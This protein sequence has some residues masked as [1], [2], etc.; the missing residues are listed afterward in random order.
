[1]EKICFDMSELWLVCG[2]EVRGGNNAW[3]E[4]LNYLFF[5]FHNDT[6]RFS[7]GEL[8]PVQ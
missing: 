6:S 3:G 8:S 5:E 4:H 2:A 7:T 1:M